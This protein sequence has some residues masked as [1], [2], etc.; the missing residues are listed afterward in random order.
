MVS[1]GLAT[2]CSGGAA[3]FFSAH[4][5]SEAIINTTA[6]IRTS[7]FIYVPPNELLASLPANLTNIGA[8]CKLMTTEIN[9]YGNVGR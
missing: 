2:G 8:H 5:I 6:R 7:L 1:E 3:T 9:G 4:P